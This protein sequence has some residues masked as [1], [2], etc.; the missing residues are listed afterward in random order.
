VLV[1]R[2]RRRVVVLL[3]AAAAVAATAMVAVG[4][5]A[6]GSAAKPKVVKVGDDYFAPVK[7]VINRN[8]RVSWKWNATF[9][10]HNVTLKR[11]P[12]GVR[13]TNFRSQTS[14]SPTYRFIRKFKKPGKYHFICTIHPVSMRMD[15]IVRR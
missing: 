10:V 12:K 15:V 3:A 13:K 1:T 4:G 2:P 9:D 14:A 8:K 11:A 5:A 7:R 6:S